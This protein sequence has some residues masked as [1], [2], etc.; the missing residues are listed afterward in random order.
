MDSE[1]QPTQHW[2]VHKWFAITLQVVILLGCAFSVYEQQW[3]NTVVIAGIFF[4]TIVP[5]LLSRRW[6]IFIPPEFE[7]L[8]IAFIFAALFLGETRDYYSRYWWWD[9]ALHTT[10]GGLLGILGL[11]LVYVLNETPRLDLHMRPG[12]IAFFA[13]CFAVTVGALWE[14]FEFA[15]DSFFGMNMQKP[16]FKDPT[17]LTDTMWDLIVDTLGALVVSALGYLYMKRRS[18]SVIERWIQRFIDGNPRLFSRH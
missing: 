11:L 16:M 17:G 6:D 18:K 12:F 3:L 14:I 1:Q 8:T 13:F 15:M 7:L 5:T 2:S 4:L 9:I 10:S